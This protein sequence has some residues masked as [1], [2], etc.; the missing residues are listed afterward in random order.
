MKTTTRA[1]L[2]AA[3]GDDDFVRL[4]ARFPG[5]LK[6]AQAYMR[7]QPVIRGGGTIHLIERTGAADARLREELRVRRQTID[8]LAAEARQ[9]SA[10]TSPRSQPKPLH[11]RAAPPVMKADSSPSWLLSPRTPHLDPQDPDV[12]MT[13]RHEAGHVAACACLGWHVTEVRLDAGGGGYTGFQSPKDLDRRLR[14]QQ[15]A[16]ICLA[17]RAHTGW[18]YHDGDKQDRWNAHKEL[19]QIGGGGQ[20][21][22]TVETEVSQLAASPRFRAIARRVEEALLERGK[23]DKQELTPLL[24]G[25]SRESARATW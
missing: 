2:R 23:L 25:A 16:I 22:D 1:Q 19:A 7:S 12:Q 10:A 18:T 6:A 8:R 5:G 4:A 13:A 17:G 11:G 14:H 24:H 20:L 21:R 3:I 15:Q 9:R